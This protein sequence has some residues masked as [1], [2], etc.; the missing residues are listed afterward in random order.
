MS[1][2]PDDQPAGLGVAVSTM[3]NPDDAIS[4]KQ[5]NVFDWC[6]EGNVEQVQRHLVQ[7]ADC[8]DSLDDAVCCAL[9]FPASAPRL[10]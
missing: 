6:K 5:K 10:V 4:D 8:V 9:M 3:C 1:A 2:T 7:M